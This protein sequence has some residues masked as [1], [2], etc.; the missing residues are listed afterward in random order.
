MR[1]GISEFSYGF[2]ITSEFVQTPGAVTAAPEFPSL[3]AE[4]QRGWDVQLDQ[5]G[6][7]LFLQFKLC[8]QMTRRTCR[9]AQQ[10]GFNVPCYRMHLR[11]AR[12][13]RQHEM[14]L[15]LEETGEDVYYVAPMFHQ[16]EELNDAFRG[17]AVR[18]RSVWL[19]PS[20]IGPLPDDRDH[21]VSFEPG[22]RWM[23]FPEPLPIDAPLASASST[24]RTGRWMRFSEPMPIKAKREFEDVEKHLM[25]RLREHSRV[26][27]SEERLEKLAD[28]I[29]RIADKRHDIGQRE[30]DA[31]R[32]AARP[33]APLQRIAYYAS[34]F[35]ESQVFVV[36]ERQ[37]T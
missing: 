17:G 12:S 22:S 29:A 34:V 15:D 30:R 11:P 36:R 7:L 23:R 27:L 10:E 20:D 28:V 14:L 35:L 4:G 6:V 31:S 1:P 3:R 16:P 19:R 5:H 9:E 8:D 26:A 21:H 32:D 13:S 33:A 18:A 24:T 2:A 37:T 25:D